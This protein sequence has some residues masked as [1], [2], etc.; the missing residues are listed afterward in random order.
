MFQLSV[1]AR[2]ILAAAAKNM[3]TPEVA[4]NKFVVNLNTMR[5]FNDFGGTINFHEVGRDW[6][7]LKSDERLAQRDALVKQLQKNARS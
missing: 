3:W 2:E 5:E 6:V 1:Y 4:V 7:K